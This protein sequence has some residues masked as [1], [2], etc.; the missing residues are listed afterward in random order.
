MKALGKDFI[1]AALAMLALTVMLGI[2]YPLLVTGVGQVAFP[3][4][5]NGQQ[6]FVHGR[7]VGSR[8]IGQNF[9]GEPRYFQ[10]RP[11]ATAPPNNAA[12]T[13]FSNFGP[14]STVTEAALKK[15][16]AAY[17][18]LNGSYYP[19]GLTAARVPVDAA[20]TSASGIDPQI[21]VRNADIQAY[22]IA[23]VR[24]MPLARVHRL[25]SRYTSGRGLGFTGAH[26]HKNWDNPNFRKF[27]LNAI[28]WTAKLDVP[29][30]GVESHVTAEELKEN[31]DLK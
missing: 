28:F 17:I 18:K 16:I 3:G 6:V 7:L 9:R 26:Y 2:L 27:V 19:G 22:R 8:I 1:R 12:A 20:S 13:S 10:G 31:L 11:S 14:N 5:A 23:A 4:N 15:N 24:H 30:D 21:S 29:A 25:I